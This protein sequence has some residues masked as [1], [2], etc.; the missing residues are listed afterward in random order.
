MQSNQVQPNNK[1]LDLERYVPALVTFL[2]NKLSSGASNCYRK[3]FDIGV[4]EWR[5]LAMLKIEPNISANRISHVIG[6]DK[7]AISRGLKHLLESELVSF[8]KDSKDARSSLI[9]L[10]AKGEKLHDRVLLVALEREKLLL[11]GLSNQELDILVKAL[12][13]LNQNVKKV[14]AFDPTLENEYSQAV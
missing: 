2:S 1:Q 14:N 9:S 13:K 11:S 5:I 8:I 7:A 4:I 10:T 3:H 12:L 6:L